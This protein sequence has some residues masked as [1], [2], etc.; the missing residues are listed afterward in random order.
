MN[1][2]RTCIIRLV[3]GSLDLILRFHQRRV[4][5]EHNRRWRQNLNDSAVIRAEQ[6]R[7]THF[8]DRYWPERPRQLFDGHFVVRSGERKI[9]EFSLVI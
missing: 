3:N 9:I 7:T 5:K 1:S 6:G 4:V 8:R 2:L